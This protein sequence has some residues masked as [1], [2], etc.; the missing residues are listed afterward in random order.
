MLRPCFLF[1]N[2]FTSSKLVFISF[3]FLN[4]MCGFVRTL[5]CWQCIASNC[6]SD[7]L[8]HPYASQE[9][10]NSGQF[11]QKVYY[12]MTSLFEQKTYMSTVRS[13]AIECTPQND[14]ANCS[15]E[16][17]TTRGCSRRVCCRDK[18]LC[19]AALPH[20]NTGW[21]IILAPIV[22]M[23]VLRLILHPVSDVWPHSSLLTWRRYSSH[24]ERTI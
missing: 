13:C 5:R 23:G 10:C 20:H 9:D 18:D 24:S 17:L 4:F 21:H 1:V 15:M 22:S 8:Y 3:I 19:N 14:F 7:P 16:R 12:E 2:P 6:D 11:C